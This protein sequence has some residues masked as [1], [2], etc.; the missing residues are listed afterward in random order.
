MAPKTAWLQTFSKLSS[1]VF[2]TKSLIQVWNYLRVSKWQDFHFGWTIPLLQILLF[3]NIQN[4]PFFYILKS[5]YFS[6]G[7]AKITENIKGT[8]NLIILQMW[9]YKLYLNV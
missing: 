8:S 4:T 3:I 9:D 1:F 7:Y 6:L 5:L 2:R